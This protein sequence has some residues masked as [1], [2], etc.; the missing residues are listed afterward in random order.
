MANTF[1]LENAK[2]SLENGAKEAAELI[3]DPSKIDELLKNLEEKLKTVPVAGSVIADVPLMI[4]MVKSY[5]KKEYT[6]V[7]PKVIISMV[8]AFI[9]LI[10]GKD[11]IPD[12]IA[13]IGH[14]DDI[15]IFAAALKLVEPE[16]KAYAEWRDNN[17][18]AEESTNA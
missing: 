15:A 6:V 3:K 1:N 10:K 7:S 18:A 5:I 14:L 8:S 16:L 4:S 13:F 17:A 2:E 12:D 9:Y 11:L